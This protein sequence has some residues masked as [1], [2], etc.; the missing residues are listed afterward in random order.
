MEKFNLST[1][2]ITCF[3]LSTYITLSMSTSNE[4][5]VLKHCRDE[6]M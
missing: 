3:N 4:D 6:K 2:S 1:N 5:S